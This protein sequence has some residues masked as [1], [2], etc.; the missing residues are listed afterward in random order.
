[1]R[2]SF[3]GSLDM[4][5]VDRLVNRQLSVEIQPSGRACFVD[6]EGRK[7]ALWVNADPD[8]TEK[9][10]QARAEWALLERRK[11]E[12]Q[13]KLQEELDNELEELVD[14]IGAEEVLKWLR[15]KFQADNDE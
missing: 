4:D 3:G 14:R 9:G 10:K 6:R 11:A 12:E 7:V 2:G 13:K 15:K 1:M 5:T 8:I